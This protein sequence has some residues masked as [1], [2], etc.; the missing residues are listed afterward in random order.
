MDE[1]SIAVQQESN[2]IEIINGEAELLDINTI[3][4][5][6]LLTVQIPGPAGPQGI[7]GPTG[8]TGAQGPTGATG[9]TGPTGPQG[10]IGDTG[11]QGPQGI[12]GTR[13]KNVVPVGLI[14]GINRLYTLPDA[15]IEIMD[16]QLNGIGGEYFSVYDF[17]RIEL[18]EAPLTGDT[19][20]VIYSY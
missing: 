9:A 2:I 19:L 1:L 14:N 6:E 7:Q 17:N 20:K 11:P 3:T 13:I 18:G 4:E 16:V 15:Y 5:V 12:P 10:P 8:A